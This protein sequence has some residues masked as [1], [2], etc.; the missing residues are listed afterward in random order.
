MLLVAGEPL[1]VRTLARL[2]QTDSRAMERALAQLSGELDGRG[3]RLQ[4]HAARVQLVT[5]PENA[6]I[7]R[8]FLRLPQQPRVSRSALE[9]LA[10]VSYRQPVTRGE[11]EEMRGVGAE[12]VLGSLIARGLIEEV[13]REQSPG[14]PIQYGTTPAFLEMFGLGCIE[15]LPPEQIEGP[16]QASLEILGMASTIPRS[17]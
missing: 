7:V 8:E 3:V 15:D 5:A 6:G 9:T 17:E 13:G 12:R 11:I 14:R 4:M 2:F 10:I 1:S 16:K